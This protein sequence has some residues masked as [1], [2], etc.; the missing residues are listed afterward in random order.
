MTQ[1]EKIIKLK[2]ML[3]EDTPSDEE[4]ITLLLVSKGAILNARYPLGEWQEE[5]VPTRYE[6]IQLLMCV[7]LFNKQGAE[8]QTSHSE[9]G[10]TRQY[11]EGDIPHSLLKQIIPM[12]G[13]VT[14]HEKP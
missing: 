7:S 1:D 5:E 2:S 11:E 12:A 9:N 6:H 4:L 14:V 13:S 3:G 8:G 10:I